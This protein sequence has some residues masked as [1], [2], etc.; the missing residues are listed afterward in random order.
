[1]NT[2]WLWLLLVLFICS[3][4]PP[5]VTNNSQTIPITKTAS[6]TEPAATQLPN[7]PLLPQVAEDLIT[8]FEVSSTS[9][10]GVDGGHSY[11]DKHYQ[12]ATF[13]GIGS[14]PTIAIGVDL[15]MQS[16]EVTTD[17]WSPY[18]SPLQVNRYA[19]C[20]GVTK[21]SVVKQLV[22]ELQDITIK[23]DTALA[24]F[25]THEVVNYWS[26][27]RRTFPGFDNLTLNCQGALV[28]TVY[29]RG[30]SMVGDSRVDLR[31]IRSLVNQDKPDYKAIANAFR[32]M[33]VTMRASWQ[34]EGIYAGLKARYDATAQL[35]ETPDE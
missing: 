25:N 29:N 16:A 24:E 9:S 14:G 27:T 6:I 20:A 22:K 26:L 3:C 17:C 21:S 19:A 7:A 35:A 28:A 11:Y 2:R 12:T 10:S 8:D 30:S 23:W 5:P 18:L 1:M 32:H 4:S 34:A 15:G 31:T 33:E 13:A